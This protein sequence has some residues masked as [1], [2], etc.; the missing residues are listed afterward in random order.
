MKTIIN[1]TPHPITILAP[2]AP[3]DSA[4]VL[5]LSAAPRGAVA[6]VESSS[7]EVGTVEHDGSQVAVM[8]TRWGRPIGVRGGDTQVVSAITAAAMLADGYDLDSVLVPA[9]QVR[10]GA[11]R[12][13]G[14]R[15]LVRGIDAVP[16]L[17]VPP[18][19][20]I[21]GSAAPL[22]PGS[23]PGD[24]DVGYCG[25]SAADAAQV[26]SRWAYEAGLHGL[27]LDLRLLPSKD[28]RIQV[29]RPGALPGEVDPVLDDDALVI[30]GSPGFD[31]ADHFGLPAVLRRADAL[32]A[33]DASPAPG[34]TILGALVAGL[35][36]SFVLLL[37]EEAPADMLAGSSYDTPTLGAVRRAV[38]RLQRRAGIWG[39]VKAAGGNALRAKLDLL[40][41]LLDARPSQLDAFRERLC[42]VGSA[43]AGTYRSAARAGVFWLGAKFEQDSP[44][45]GGEYRNMVPAGVADRIETLERQL[46]ES[47][48][49]NRIACE[50]MTAALLKA[51]EANDR[52][53]EAWDEVGALRR[54]LTERATLSLND[55][56]LV[57]LT[58]AG[59]AK[60]LADEV[61]I[62]LPPDLQGHQAR[63]DA[64]GWTRWALWDFA[65]TLGPHLGM[66]REPPCEMEVRLSS[67]DGA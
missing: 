36:R 45:V 7:R 28:G 53:N 67:K 26:A 3:V 55:Q 41:A 6:R 29:P 15:G 50:G 27:P 62:G 43:P 47:R 58:D 33:R 44:F 14:C 18:Q 2:D 42:P 11:G 66:G 51:R 16:R 49:S 59:R 13:V 38:R 23:D 19:V 56:I 35:A 32:L 10:D 8:S 60:V 25:M 46:A 64:E 57:R 37:C 5:T 40:D 65:A 9:D 48:E 12:I 63:A 17:G 24:I 21:F 52:T 4:P 61:R 22:H 31:F 54:Q 20:V 39:E 1:R 30:F 34:L